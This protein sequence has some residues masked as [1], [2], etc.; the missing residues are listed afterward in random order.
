M[1][2]EAREEVSEGEIY[3]E[4]VRR[5]LGSDFVIAVRATVREIASNPT[6]SSQAVPG[7]YFRK[8]ERFP[9]VVFYQ[10]E[11]KEVVIIVVAHQR[12]E[13][14]YWQDRLPRP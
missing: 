8:L 14:G 9:Y 4:G 11:A 2:A 7:I 13:P 12:R 1:L 5:G 6:F 3:Y 10:I